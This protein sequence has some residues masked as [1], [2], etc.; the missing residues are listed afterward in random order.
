MFYN[1]NGDGY[2]V[3]PFGG[4]GTYPADAKAMAKTIT[5]GWINFFNTLDPNG[6]K[7][8]KL[9]SGNEWPVYDL[10]DGPYGKGVVFSINGT[11]IEVD[12]W[13]SGGMEWFAEHSLAVFGN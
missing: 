7:G 1:T 4:D 5:T 2:D 10:S 3:N 9:F 13:R 6:K 8:S 12:D 11:H